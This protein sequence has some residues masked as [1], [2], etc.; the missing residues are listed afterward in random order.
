MRTAFAVQINGKDGAIDQNGNL[1]IP[2]QFECLYMFFEGY[3]SFESNGLHGVVDTFGNI[4]CEPQ[5]SDIRPFQEG[6]AVIRAKAL[7]G[8]INTKGQQIVPCRFWEARSFSCG[9]AAAQEKWGTGFGFINPAGEYHIP[10]RFDHLVS[11]HEGLSPA[12]LRTPDNTG[13]AGYID[14]MGEFAIGP[15]YELAHRFAEGLAA[16][17]ANK[18][19]TRFGFIDKTGQMR[20]GP[21]FA[22]ADL[23]FAEGRAMVWKDGLFGYIDREG[24]LAIPYAYHFCDHFS[25]GLGRVI[26]E[27]NGK[28][29][30]GFIN[31]AG[32]MVIEP[33]F[34][35]A[36]NFHHGLASVSDSATSGYINT[37]GEYVW[38]D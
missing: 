29:S 23:Q 4:V 26:V 30:Y 32:E 13:L 8:Y 5:Y 3:A 18:R 28:E 24:N 34:S 7:S 35:V 1:I 27:R 37:Q 16:V 36:S 25:C 22:G 38:R 31:S 10:P 33:R 12:R 14:T 2:P 19:A 6:Y 9:L 11:F 20:I 17:S 21:H 15:K